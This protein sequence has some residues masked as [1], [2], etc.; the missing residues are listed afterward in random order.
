MNRILQMMSLNG[1]GLG[2]VSVFIPIYLLELGY[3]FYMV[4]LWLIIHH[5]TLLIGAFVTV[6]ISNRIGLIRCLYIRFVLLIASLL[7]L[8]VLPSYPI[9]FYIIPIISGFESALYWIPLNILFVRKTETKTMGSSMSKFFNYPKIIG[10]FAPLIGAFIITKFSYPVLFFIAMC[11]VFVSMIPLLPLRSEKTHFRFTWAA[12]KEIW[13][14]NKVYFIPEIVDNFAEDAGVILTLF[15][16]LNLLNVLDIGWIGTVT[17]LV[18]VLFTYFVGD[19]TDTK[20][21]HKLI[22]VGAVLLSLSWCINFVIGE[23]I[24]YIWL[25]YIA[26]II[27]TLSLKTFLVPYQSLMFNSARASHDA[28]FLVLREV[29]TIIGRFIVYGLA[30]ALHNHLPVV[31]LIIALVFVYFWFFDTRKLAS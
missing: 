25:F 23:F 20:N 12:V 28:Q 26:T 19:M 6:Y 3:P 1:L 9:L 21:K 8:F 31:F 15:I 5:G 24:P 18:V 22:R 29:P 16:Y 11:L 4:M 30:L 10:L 17:S 2:L 7:L 14:K 13:Q 27:T